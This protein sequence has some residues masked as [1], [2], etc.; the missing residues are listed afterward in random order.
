LERWHAR[1]LHA[2]VV[3]EARLS[4]TEH[5][6]QVYLANHPN[7][8]TKVGK[9]L[10]RFNVNALADSRGSFTSAFASSWK[11]RFVLIRMDLLFSKTVLATAL[12]SSLDHRQARSDMSNARSH[13]RHFL[14]AH[15][16]AMQLKF[17]DRLFASWHIF[18]LPLVFLLFLAGVTHVVAVHWY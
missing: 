1:L 3:A 11:S 8:H 2:I 9:L 18:H 10:A 15:S 7:T 5:A 16:A 4:E 6:A 14:S 12:K 17:W 13:I